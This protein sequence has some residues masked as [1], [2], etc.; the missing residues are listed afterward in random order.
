MVMVEL[1]RLL[2]TLGG[3]CASLPTACDVRGVSIDSRTIGVGELY[4]ALPGRVADGAR[5]VPEA[6]ARGA[7]AVLSPA[8]LRTD[9]PVWV[10]ERARA[11]AGEAAAEVAGRPSRDMFTV[12]ITGTNGKTTIAHLAAH[13]MRHVGLAPAVLGTTGNTLAGGVT[14]DATHTTPDA[15][16]LQALLARHRDLGGDAVALEASSHALEQERLAGLEVDVAVFANLSRDHLDYHGDME[17]YAAA[18]ALLFERLAP[19]AHAVLNADDPAHE[20]MA[21]AARRAGAVV[22]TFSTRSRADL[23]ASRL[24]ID[25]KGTRFLFHGMG[26]SRTWVQIPLVG[27]FNV[28]NALAALLAVLMSGASPSDCLEGLATVIPAPGRLESV[29]TGDR[30]FALLVDYAHTPDALEQVLSTLRET[31]EGVQG[32]RLICVFGC[33]GERDVG[34]RGPMGRVAADLADLAILTSDNPRGE[35]PTA[36][37]EAVLAGAREVADAEVVVELDR[38]A[39]IELAVR[40]A[41]PGDVVLIAGKGHEAVQTIGDR[42]LEFSDRRAAAEAVRRSQES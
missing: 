1:E 31:L 15:P 9:V 30:E 3:S 32:G 33:G 25:S 27:R 28:E 35:D 39:A 42:A 20:R 13:L 2:E 11:I 24:Q 21:A 34:K 29:P 26:I 14:V 6:V 19:G 16:A 10:H 7:V 5:F 18:K 41:R 40:E 4:A 23:R 12:A 37:A 36:I 8:P 22:H 17:S 38:R